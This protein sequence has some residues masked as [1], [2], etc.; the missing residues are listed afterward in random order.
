MAWA[1]GGT[2]GGDKRAGTLEPR[3]TRMTRIHLTQKGSDTNFT[4][5]RQL[6]STLF[7]IFQEGF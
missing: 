5:L 7:F 6:A 4:N 1:Q 2:A 3:M